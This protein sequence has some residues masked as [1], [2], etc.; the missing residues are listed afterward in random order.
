[1]QFPGESLAIRMWE[2][3]TEKGIG[4]LFRPWQMRREGLAGMELKRQELLMLARAEREVEAIKNSAAPQE[5]LALPN[6]G[7]ARF[8]PN[9]DPIKLAELA[10][11]IGVSETVRK[12]VNITRAL[13]HAETQLET[14]SGPVPEESVESDWLSRW[15]DSAAEVSSEKLQQLWGKVLAGEVKSPG[16]YSL[17]TLDFLRNLSTSEAASI[18]LLSRF[19]VGGM[20]FREAQDILDRE[21][22][23]FDFLIQMQQL[24]VMSGVESIGMRIDYSSNVPDR[25]VHALTSH[26]KILVVSSDDPTRTFSVPAY[27]ITLIGREIFTLGVFEPHLPYLRAIGEHIKKQD[28]VVEI[29]RYEPAEA[30]T[31]RCY[32]L[33]PV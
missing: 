10:H 7:S 12:E 3:V 9:I 23:T 6:L 19:V 4:A 17:R 27:H 1:M 28:F 31:V 20:I 8:E 11:Q 33:H 13:L 2:T 15:R 21:G 26:G 25:F 14:E 30:G 24:G 16:S 5:L 22:V 32:E 18:S 29:G